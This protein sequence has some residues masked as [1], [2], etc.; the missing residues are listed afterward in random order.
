MNRSALI[1]QVQKELGDT[2][3]KAE[4]QRAVDAVLTGISRGL[5]KKGE[6]VVQLVG[7]GT[8][9]VVKRAARKGRNPQTGEEIKIKASKSVSFKPGKALKDKL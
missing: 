4:A 2:A 7:F 6:G 8:F 1:E 3:T 5:T 9:R